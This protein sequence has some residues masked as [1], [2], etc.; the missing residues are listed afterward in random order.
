M[1]SGTFQSAH[2]SS[3]TCL[4]TGTKVRLIKH[5]YSY[6]LQRKDHKC[7]LVCMDSN[8]FCIQEVGVLV[9]NKRSLPFETVTSV[10]QRQM[11]TLLLHLCGERRQRRKMSKLSAARHHLLLCVYCVLMLCCPAG[12]MSGPPTTSV[13]ASGHP[14]PSHGLVVGSNLQMLLIKHSVCFCTCT[15]LFILKFV[16]NFL[17]DYVGMIE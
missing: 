4:R 10:L 5:V 7:L 13:Q 11:T 16:F 1:D 9:S 15:C 8:Q 3:P 6:V 2:G 17:A 12:W 14:V